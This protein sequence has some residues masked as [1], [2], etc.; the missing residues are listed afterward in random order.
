[1][2]NIFLEKSYTTIKT[3]IILRTRP[4][5]FTLYKAF[6]KDQKRNGTSLL[7]S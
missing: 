1:M 3:L 5:A 6:L 4:L 2:E 7:A